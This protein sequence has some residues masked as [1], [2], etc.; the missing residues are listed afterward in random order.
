MRRLA[1]FLVI[2]VGL[3]ARA[4]RDGRAQTHATPR[5]TVPPDWNTDCEYSKFRAGPKCRSWNAAWAKREVSSPRV[6]LLKKIEEMRNV[7]RSL[8]PARSG[9]GVGKRVLEYCNLYPTQCANGQIG[10]LNVG[11]MH[12][13]CVNTEAQCADVPSNKFGINYH[14][15]SS[16][17]DFANSGKIIV[18]STHT[19]V[20]MWQRALLTFNKKKIRSTTPPCTPPTA[21][22][23]PACSPRR[24]A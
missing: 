2:F 15:T 11:Y 8:Q 10:R 24:G 17:G 6:G 3:L 20:G 19:A 12:G 21:P 16:C 18:L 7:G 22:C 14:M 9:S 23:P 4:P 13:K 1:A 5:L